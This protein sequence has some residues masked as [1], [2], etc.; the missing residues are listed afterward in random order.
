MPVYASLMLRDA[1]LN[2]AQ[3]TGFFFFENPCRD[4]YIVNCSSMLGWRDGGQH[5]EEYAFKLMHP[6]KS[7]DFRVMHPRFV[8]PYT[9][10]VKSAAKTIKRAW[11]RCISDPSY[12][13]CCRRLRRE[14]EEFEPTQNLTRLLNARTSIHVASCEPMV[15]HN[16]SNLA[17]V[18]A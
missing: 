14:F 16:E 12:D 13:L 11:K 10:V 15:C 7:F 1:L 18:R 2:L 8:G 6:R 4:G 9:S 17:G 3:A 5:A